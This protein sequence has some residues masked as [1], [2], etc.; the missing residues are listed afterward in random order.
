MTVT[1]TI[2]GFVFLTLNIIKGEAIADPV[3]PLAKKITVKRIQDYLNGINTFQATITQ[4]NPDHQKLTGTVSINRKT[5]GTYGKLRIQY[6]QKDQ[7]LVIA[8]GQKLI[9]INPL[10]KEKT[11]YEISQ[12]PAAFLLQKKLDLEEDYT[13]KSFKE[14]GSEIELTM[15]KFG[16][17]DAYVTLRFSTDPLLKFNGWKILDLQGNQTDVSLSNVVI[18]IS[19]SPTLFQV[20]K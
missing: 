2:I 3:P 5:N 17:G 14:K 8:D 12:T 1:K 4:T 15:T 10:T 16:A 7:D 18:G 20:N 6:D 9:L 13:I 19:L 11:D